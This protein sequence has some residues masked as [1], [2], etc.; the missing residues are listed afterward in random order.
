MSNLEMMFVFDVDGGF[1]VYLQG[2]GRKENHFQ[3]STRR[4]HSYRSHFWEAECQAIG[5]K[6][7]TLTESC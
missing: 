5:S 3:R 4:S 1:K 2:E 6:T 7:P